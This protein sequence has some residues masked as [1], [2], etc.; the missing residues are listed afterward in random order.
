M[1]GSRISIR[2]PN[3][4]IAWLRRVAKLAATTP[5]QVIV[6]IIAMSVVGRGRK[7]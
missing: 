1:K 4:N 3:G 7:R 5:S 2:V 6:V